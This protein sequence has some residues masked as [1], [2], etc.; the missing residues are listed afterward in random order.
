MVITSIPAHKILIEH[1]CN[2]PGKFPLT[3]SP[4]SG[5]PSQSSPAVRRISPSRVTASAAGEGQ[6]DVAG[7]ERPTVCVIVTGVRGGHNVVCMQAC[8]YVHNYSYS[9]IHIHTAVIYQAEHTLCCMIVCM[10]V[11]S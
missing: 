1:T 6:K 7:S 4:H 9:H 10:C 3:C 11:K 8:I 2:M 5:V